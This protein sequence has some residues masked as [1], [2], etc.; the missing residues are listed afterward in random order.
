M[1]G[2]SDGI[3]FDG[4]TLAELHERFGK[5]A[6]V[7][8]PPDVPDCAVH[9]LRWFFELSNRR[10]PAFS[11]VSPLTFGDIAAWRDLLGVLVEPEEVRMLLDIDAAFRKAVDENGKSSKSKPQEA[12]PPKGFFKAI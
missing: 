11:G 7:P 9:V 6:E 3:R 4:E 8:D 12:P 1:G 2:A 5:G 10:Q